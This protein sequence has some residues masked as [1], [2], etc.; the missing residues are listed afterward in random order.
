MKYFKDIVKQVSKRNNKVC[1]DIFLCERAHDSTAFVLCDGIGSGIY[2]N[3]AAISCAQR[4]MELFRKNVSMRFACETVAASMHRARQED[5]P[6]AAFSVAKIY[7]D[8][9]FT[10]YN[11]EAPEPIIIKGET[12]SPL[13]PH[14]FTAGYEVV[15]ESSSK[16]DLGD[17]LMLCSDGVT[18][19]GLGNGY[20]FGIGAGG[21]AEYMNRR[22]NQGYN[23]E[24]LAD[25][26]IEMSS[27]ISGGF[28]ADDTTVAFLN[29]KKAKQLALMTGPPS[30]KSH[31]SNYVKRFMG[32]PGKHVICGSS[33]ADIVS[34]ELKLDVKMKKTVHSLNS[35]PEYIMEGVDMVTEGAIVLNQ[36][37]NI[38]DENP[39]Q[40][41]GNTPAERLCLLLLEA[42]VINFLIGKV[43]NDAHSDLLFKQ[44]GV[45]PR[46]VAV[47]L[48]MEKL[49][50]KGK[51]VIDE[52]F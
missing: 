25:D 50:K 45:R 37:Y 2:A 48:I 17:S 51:L 15:G 27:R 5:I 21:T 9:R 24:T 13:K 33:T 42:D 49:R 28:Y 30:N 3:I 18:Q 46:F 38:I 32:Y 16:L 20:L 44:M 52:H 10:A 36:V 43:V 11:Y 6:F 41:T 1:G 8:G 22:L 40:L 19:A 47:N 29:C 14:F 4:L 31:D 12:A 35:P 39:E 34:R 7:N 26:I 23:L